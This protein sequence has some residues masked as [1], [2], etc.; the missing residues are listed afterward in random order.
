MPSFVF[1]VVGGVVATAGVVVA[2][3]EAVAVSTSTSVDVAVVVVETC[4]CT[5][6]G[7]QIDSPAAI[8]KTAKAIVAIVP[9]VLPTRPR[10]PAISI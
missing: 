10:C 6:G 2:V 9:N 7:M 3:D 1:F 5:R 4:A 8:A